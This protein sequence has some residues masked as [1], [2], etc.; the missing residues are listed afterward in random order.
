MSTKS[1]IVCTNDAHIYSD[2]SQQRHWAGKWL[3]DDICL[4]ID[5]RSI[6]NVAIKD[7]MIKIKLHTGCDLVQEIGIDEIN[8]FGGNI[9]SFEID[10]DDL[11]IWIVGGSTSAKKILEKVFV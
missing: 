2:C 8:L 7:V 10:E 1:S 11:M 4:C 5:K 3:G 9:D 6:K